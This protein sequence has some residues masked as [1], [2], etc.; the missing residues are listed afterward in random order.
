MSDRDQ[1]RSEISY[2]WQFSNETALSELQQHRLFCLKRFEENTNEEALQFER[3]LELVK[4][5]ERP[6][7]IA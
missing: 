3:Y 2:I 6:T 7:A 5:F 1:S 4:V